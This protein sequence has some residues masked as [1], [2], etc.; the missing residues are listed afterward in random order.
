MEVKS[1]AAFIK[2]Y[3]RTRRITTDVLDVIPPDKINWTY[4]SGKFTI[5]DL[6]RHIATIE[7]YVFMEVIQGNKPAY[8]GC[9]KELADGYQDT[10]RYFHEMHRQ[11]IEILSSMDDGDLHK[12]IRTL[13]GKITAVGNFLRAL[14]VHEVH[15]RGALCIYLNL[16]G[17][18]TPPVIGLMEEQVIQLSK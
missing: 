1:I 2:Y 8:K 15:H 6:V 7:R 18:T 4:K 11:S 14:V 5:G 12:E 10:I 16:L 17:V 9:G 13:D 3:E